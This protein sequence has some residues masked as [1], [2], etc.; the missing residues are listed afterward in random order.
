MLKFLNILKYV[1]LE[2]KNKMWLFNLAH[3]FIPTWKKKTII[4]CTTFYSNIMYLTFYPNKHYFFIFRSIILFIQWIYRTILMV[5]LSPSIQILCPADSLEKQVSYKH[6]E[7][8]LWIF[9]IIYI[10]E[11]I[12]WVFKLVKTQESQFVQNHWFIG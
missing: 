4:L 10:F 1:F 7:L 5:S 8:V 6:K 11:S 9:S 12:Y 2:Y 3:I